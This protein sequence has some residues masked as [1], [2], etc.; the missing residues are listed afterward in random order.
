MHLDV[1]VIGPAEEANKI[2]TLDEALNDGDEFSFGGETVK[3]IA[4]PGHTLGMINFY[5][6]QSGVVFT[7]DTLFALGCG[8]IFE[9]DPQM[10][11]NS[12]TKLMALPE[13][14]IVYCGHEYTLANAKFSLTIDPENSALALRADEIEALRAA[15]ETYTA[16]H[17]RCGIG[18][19]PVSTG[20]RSSHSN[21]SG[22]GECE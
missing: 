7:G 3:V 20:E 16:D 15:G 9:G 11:W 10:M 5:F 14:T 12:L 4:T 1:H 8:R 13:E 18:D 21:A 6:P 2:S 17:N 19:Q 22:Y